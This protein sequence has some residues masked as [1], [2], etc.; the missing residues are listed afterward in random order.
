MLLLHENATI[1]T[2]KR[3]ASPAFAARVIFWCRPGPPAALTARFHPARRDRVDV[4]TNRIV[5]RAQAARI[6]R[7]SKE[8]LDAFDR[9]SNLLVGD[10]DPIDVVERAS[11]YTPVPGGV[12]LLTIA[13]LMMNTVE[14]AERRL[15]GL[16]AA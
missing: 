1:A 7:N 10:I 9:K 14:A 8:K 6:F 3:R 4:G 16:H 15:G 13:M 5:D 11:A 12:G 2:P